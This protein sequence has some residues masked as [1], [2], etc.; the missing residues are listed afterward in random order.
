MGHKAQYRFS[1]GCE[2]VEVYGV[3]QIIQYSSILDGLEAF[4]LVNREV[5]GTFV[6]P[7]IGADVLYELATVNRAVQYVYP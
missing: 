5:T 6:Y 2:G 7:Q 3:R 1:C 4:Q